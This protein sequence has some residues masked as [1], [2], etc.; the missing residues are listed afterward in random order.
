MSEGRS[1]T[2]AER[3]LQFVTERREAEALRSSPMLRIEG[4]E[5]VITRRWGGLNGGEIRDNRAIP[6]APAD[7]GRLS[8]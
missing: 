7:A 6:S 2:H 3:F 8:R 1:L 5:L 4:D